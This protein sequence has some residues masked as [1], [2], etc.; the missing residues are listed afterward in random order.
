V[1]DVGRI[2][3]EVSS[4]PSGIEELTLHFAIHETGHFFQA[5][6]AAQLSEPDPAIVSAIAALERHP[7]RPRDVNPV[8]GAA[9]SDPL[10]TNH[11]GDF[12]RPALHL[13][14]RAQAVGYPVD[15]D[16]CSIAGSTYGLSD[17]GDYADALGDELESEQP[18]FDILEN[19]APEPFRELFAA[20][21][22]CSEL[23]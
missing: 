12:I 22:R 20:D 2:R 1:F 23:P 13:A 9:P 8:S 5:G 10:W 21:T 19:A 17:A 18:L 15:V 14:R 6:R 7:T 11:G 16:R 4:D 3:A